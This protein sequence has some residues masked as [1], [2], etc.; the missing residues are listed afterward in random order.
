M[1]VYHMN[2]LHQDLFIYTCPHCTDVTV[3]LQDV[4]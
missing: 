4:R 3:D 1:L 2:A